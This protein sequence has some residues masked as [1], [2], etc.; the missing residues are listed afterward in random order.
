M[1]DSLPQPQAAT[2]AGE[3]PVRDTT[4]E[5]AA[6]FVANKRDFLAFLERRV[7]SRAVAEDILQEAFVR[8][9]GRL[10]TEDEGSVIAW[11]YRSLRNAA[12]DHHRR[13]KSANKALEALAAE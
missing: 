3:S 12:I 10:H 5:V 1:S 2:G 11:F 8:G 6:I 13:H 4:A 9:M 7:G